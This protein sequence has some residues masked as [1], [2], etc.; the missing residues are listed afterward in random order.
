MIVARRSFE[1]NIVTS[2]AHASS[3]SHAIGSLSLSLS[4]SPSRKAA[5]SSRSGCSRTNP[6][7]R[8][9]A[10]VDAPFSAVSNRARF[11][12]Q[13]RA[14]DREISSRSRKNSNWNFP[15]RVGIS[16][17]QLGTGRES[18][19]SIT[20][21][22][23]WSKRHAK[24]DRLAPGRVSARGGR[25]RWALLHPSSTRNTSN[26]T[27]SKMSAIAAV[28]LPALRAPVR[29]ARRTTASKVRTDWEI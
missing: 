24:Y 19:G 27:T 15:R 2:C 21:R 6:L 17:C 1:N 20:A 23:D 7:A 14:F 26:T 8:R 13:A 4:P 28:G 22:S 11:P 12:F 3:R 9:A 16:A 29:A 25:V 5:G 18:R 10:R